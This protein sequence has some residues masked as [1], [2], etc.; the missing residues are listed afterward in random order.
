MSPRKSRCRKKHPALSFFSHLLLLHQKHQPWRTNPNFWYHLLYQTPP[1]SIEYMQLLPV[2]VQY[3]MNS[4]HGAVYFK[5]IRVRLQFSSSFSLDSFKV[6]HDGSSHW[7]SMETDLTGIHE[8]AGWIPGLTQWVRDLALLW[9][10]VYITDVAQI[11]CSCGCSV[12]QQQE[13]QFSP[14]PGNFHMLQVWP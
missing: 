6:L 5:L 1:N 8:D 14:W 4:P 7:G 13:P 10:V 12:G 2:L 11:P 9:A 3:S